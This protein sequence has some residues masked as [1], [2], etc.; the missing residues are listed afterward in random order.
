MGEWDQNGSNGDW[1]EGRTDS[2]GSVNGSVAGSCGH[3][4]EPSGSSDTY[5]ILLGLDGLGLVSYCLLSRVYLR[6]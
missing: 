5:R 1:P 4:D 6:V 2:V 3:S